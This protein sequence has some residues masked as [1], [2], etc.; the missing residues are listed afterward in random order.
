MKRKA[1]ARGP[2]HKL[3]RARFIKIWNSSKSV[4]EV[5]KR[6]GWPKGLVACSA[7]ANNLRR[8]HGIKLKLLW[9]MWRAA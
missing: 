9:K 3:D 1:R 7:A 5:M 6:Y 2:Y 4:P 8:N